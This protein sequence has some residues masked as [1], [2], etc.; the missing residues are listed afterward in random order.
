MILPEKSGSSVLE[1][2][3]RV[4]GSLASSVPVRL[5]HQP[6]QTGSTWNSSSVVE[7]HPGGSGETRA[8]IALTLGSPS[9]RCFVGKVESCCL[10]DDLLTL[11]RS[12][13]VA[14]LFVSVEHSFCR[15]FDPTSFECRGSSHST[16]DSRLQ[17]N[18]VRRRFAE[19]RLQLPV[20][21]GIH[22]TTISC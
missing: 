8:G 16:V 13:F 17:L 5:F 15:E 7:S 18:F 11:I 10:E 20:S 2:S 21:T 12:G 1:W 19:N 9:N 14:I 4:S 22:L 3:I 6:L